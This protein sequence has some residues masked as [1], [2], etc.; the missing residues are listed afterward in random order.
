[1][2]SFRRERLVSSLK[3][4]GG[5]F[6]SFAFGQLAQMASVDPFA[7]IKSMINEMVEKLLKEANEEA[8]HK[9]FCDEELAKSRKSQAEKT[10]KL[11]KYSAR[12]DSATTTIAE[13]ETAIK[14]LRGELAEMDAAVAEASKIRT[15]ENEEFMKAS[16]D[17][18]DSAEAVAAAIQVLKSYYE[19]SFIQVAAKTALKSKQP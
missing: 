3:K 19:G 11:D 7:K 18:K 15:A 6:H 4:M 2:E 13:L 10:M 16:K 17:F 12:I 9:A 1:M 14:G 5:K 8:T